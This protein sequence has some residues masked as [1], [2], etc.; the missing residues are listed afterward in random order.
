MAQVYQQADTLKSFGHLGFVNRN[1]GVQSYF[2][3]C[4]SGD[5]SER[6]ATKEKIFS[7]LPNQEKSTSLV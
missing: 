7:R 4:L 3:I 5:W 6:N 1:D 2:V